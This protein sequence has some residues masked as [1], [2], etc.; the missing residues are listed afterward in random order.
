MR[1]RDARNKYLVELGGSTL[2]YIAVLF[3]SITLA[4][5]MP[6]G[7]VRSLLLLLPMIPV[8]LM[9]WAIA[10][11]FARMDEFIRLRSLEGLSIAAAVTAGLTLTY[12]F[13]E[14]AGFPRL[15][16]IWIWPLMG[17]VWGLVVCLRNLAAR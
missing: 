3:G 11:H 1:E 8:M 12:G 2:L 7:T 5:P 13:L 6:E 10:R 4:G 17:A 14:G 15:S 16:M 9:V